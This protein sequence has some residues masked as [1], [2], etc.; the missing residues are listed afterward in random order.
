MKIQVKLQ[1]SALSWKRLTLWWAKSILVR[2]VFS[3]PIFINVKSESLHEIIDKVNFDK[4]AKPGETEKE[5]ENKE[6]IE[7]CDCNTWEKN[8]KLRGKQGHS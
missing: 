3:E 7:Y 1:K 4:E 8:R 2:F 6:T 5:S